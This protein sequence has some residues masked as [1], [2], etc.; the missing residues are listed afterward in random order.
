M[1]QPP[2]Q[3]SS[4]S[5]SHSSPSTPPPALAIGV[6]S[7]VVEP[8][9]VATNSIV[10]ARPDSPA[11]TASTND[12]SS[13]STAHTHITQHTHNNNNNNNN[14]NNT[15]RPHTRSTS[16]PIHPFFVDLNTRTGKA[17]KHFRRLYA[18]TATICECGLFPVYSE[19]IRSPTSP[20]VV[21]PTE[22]ASLCLDC[23]AQVNEGY[24]DRM[25]HPST[26]RHW[27]GIPV[28]GLND[29]ETGLLWN[30]SM[31][32]TSSMY[33][34]FHTTQHRAATIATAPTVH[35]DR[36]CSWVSRL[37][38][39]VWDGLGKQRKQ[40]KEAEQKVVEQSKDTKEVKKDE[41][42]A[43]GAA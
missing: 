6:C 32:D 22:L 10:H 28:L 13:N 12:T 31:E 14:S 18:P 37:Q 35:F 4:P 39:E 41:A 30:Q 8:A 19:Q 2:S 15:T 27:S 3:P 16:D 24:V 38:R 5:H 23:I 26:P 43:E 34:K 9:T 42:V 1:T 17:A 7:E 36:A 20:A 40:V 25:K 11:P 29:R 33:D 21:L